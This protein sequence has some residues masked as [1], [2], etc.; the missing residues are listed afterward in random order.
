MTIVEIIQKQLDAGNYTAGVFI[1]LTK[2]F[3]AVALRKIL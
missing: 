1:D 2:A 3:N